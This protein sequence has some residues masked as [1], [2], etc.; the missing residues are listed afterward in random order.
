MK[1]FLEK[2]DK[3][4][5][6]SACREPNFQKDIISREIRRTMERLDPVVRE[7]TADLANANTQLEKETIEQ[8]LK[9]KFAFL[10]I[11]IL[12]HNAHFKFTN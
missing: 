2:Y 3:N 10:S 1:P 4:D 9:V 6:D 12:W 7:L 11:I 8:K 5:K